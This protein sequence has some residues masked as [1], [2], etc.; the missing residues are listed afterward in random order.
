MLL[1]LT[2]PLFSSHTNDLVELSLKARIPA[3]T[4]FRE[5]AKA[6]GLMAYGPSY[7][8]LFK[9]AAVFVDK[10]LK[11][12]KPRDLPVEQPTKFEFV[13]NRKTAQIFGIEI[14]TSLLVR[15]DEVIE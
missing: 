10:I 12:T 1:I 6:G 3:I 5:F 9:R 4:G 13:V 2:D 8:D 15:A 14:P 7:S 11:G